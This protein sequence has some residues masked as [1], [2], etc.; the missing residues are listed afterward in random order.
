L[1]RLLAF[2]TEVAEGAASVRG[3]GTSK[4]WLRWP[5][6]ICVFACLVHFETLHATEH[7]NVL[8]IHS[9]GREFRPWNEYA[10]QIRA[11][12]DRQS[13][14]PLDVREHALESARSG[15][16]NPELPFVAYLQALYVG[17]AP[18]LIVTIGAP[19]AAF[20]QR[21]RPQLFPSSAAL[22]TAVDRRR[23]QP[24]NLTENDAVVATRLDFR[25]LFESFLKIAPDTKIIAVVNGNT[26]NELFWRN[27]IE[28]ELRPLEGRIDLRWYDNL[29]FQDILK[30]TSNLP[31]HSAIFWN[32]MVA[33][34]TGVVFQGG[35][36]L[37]ALQATANAPIF[38]HD[39]AFF[40]RDVV[41]GP[42][43]SA[44][45]LGK[46]AGT[47]AVRMLKGE[48]PGGINIDPI[49]F[50]APIYDWRELQRWNINESLLPPGSEIEFREPSPWDQYRWQILLIC[51]VILLQGALISGLL[52]E[53]NRR[54]LAE[55]QLRQRLAELARSNRY[56]LAGELAA[57][58]AHEINQP[59]GAILAN[60]E[61]LGAM[62]R[63]PAPDLSEMREITADIQRDDRRAADVILHL[64]DLLKKS[65]VEVRDIDLNE[66][67]RDA[68]HFFSELA[69]AR[70]ANLISSFAPA[71]LPVK[72]NVVQLHQVVLNLIVNAVDAMSGLPVDQR[73]LSIATGRV[74]N[75]AEIVVSDTGPGIPPDKLNEIFAPF[76]STK[77]QG[78][79][80]GLS[81]ARTIIEAH[82]GRMEAANSPAGGAV[83]RI[84]LPLA[85]SPN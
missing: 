30:Q 57:T 40:G 11:E 39:H 10:Q 71:P 33:D 44:R 82:G 9:V 38:T 24:S 43:L 45:L 47:V 77:E 1:R 80:M 18:D 72:G 59:L 81:I 4:S 55:V 12:L 36:A 53:R 27:E 29:S 50:A 42:M 85:T 61:A 84:E 51:A 32:T 19:A 78:M 34:A 65:S 54:Q 76:F 21:H 58:I 2:I 16:A 62:L 70:N 48:K 5:I 23:L 69:I 56:S 68:I 79:G 83:F 20:V 60:A 67:V 22:L 37:R 74:E 73:K 63:S 15:D 7:K 28:E 6:A 25:V 64:R 46:E 14:W 52:H 35:R 8:I 75:S 41:G 31:K 17:H 3:I 26:P 13:P 49:G 66:P